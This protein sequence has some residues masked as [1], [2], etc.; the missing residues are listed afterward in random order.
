MGARFLRI[1]SCVMGFDSRPS[2]IVS[3]LNSVFVFV[4]TNWV[5]VGLTFSQSYCSGSS[6][7]SINFDITGSYFASTSNP[8]RSD[9]TLIAS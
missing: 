6:F 8:V 3:I 9:I 4:S 2:P 5:C 1:A 7:T